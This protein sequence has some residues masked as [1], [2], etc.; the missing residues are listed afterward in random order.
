MQTNM[1]VCVPPGALVRFVQRSCVFR[2]SASFTCGVAFAPFC[3]VYMLYR[4]YGSCCDIRMGMPVQVAGIYRYSNTVDRR[5][6]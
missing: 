3:L 5:R 1:S 2:L 4:Y 6:K